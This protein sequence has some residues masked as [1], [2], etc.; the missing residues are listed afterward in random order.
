MQYLYT[1]GGKP[2]AYH[3]VQDILELVE[4]FHKQMRQALDRVSQEAD[5]D[6]V[7]WLSHQ[8]R[9]HELHWEAALSGYEKRVAEGVLDTWLQYFPDEEVRRQIDA[10]EI[11]RDMTIDDL[12]D[13]NVRFR[14][15][16]INLYETLSQASSAPRV[17][18]LFQQLQEYEQ[19]VIAQQSK[20]QQDSELV[21]NRSRKRA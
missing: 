12:I 6:S 14:Q 1:K 10:I 13:L 2:M 15:A 21:E 18:E 8:L 9:Q 7:E 19:A 16:L 11:K 5:S 4:S 17:H 20:K 3:K